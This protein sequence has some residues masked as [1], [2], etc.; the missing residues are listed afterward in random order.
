MNLFKSKLLLF[1]GAAFTLVVFLSA[2]SLST[3]EKP[4]L[5][6]NDKTPLWDVM[7]SLGK[8]NV[9]IA[10]DPENK[11][12]AAQGESLVN[13]GWAMVKGKKSAKI[14]TKF[15]CVACHVSKQ[16]HS[17]LTVIDPIQRLLYAEKNDLAYL[18]GPTFHGLVNRLTFFNQDFQTNVK[19][20]NAELFKTSNL[21]I[22]E[23]IKTCNTVFNKGRDLKDWE[24]EAILMYL[25]TLELKMGD[26]KLS[27]S[28]LKS[29]KQ[30]IE[31]NA[32]TSKALF[33]LKKKY[34]EAYP[35]SFKDPMS[36]N[37][38]KSMTYT[39]NFERGRI[40]FEKGCQHCHL[41][42][43]YS[44]IK[45]DYKR[46][47]FSNLKELLD[48]PNG[49]IY[50]AHRYNS[51]GRPFYTAERLS[52]NQLQDLRYFIKIVNQKGK[53]GAFEYYGQ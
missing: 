22:R 39:G 28:E 15:N 12:M 29:V 49:S 24:T 18:P 10:A 31:N 3:S 16:E 36:I 2:F 17:D 13:N 46:K 50:T 6:I 51:A 48:M 5:D 34:I 19:G 43:P 41:N 38:R 35:A 21:K 11:T 27:A 42:N 23:A 7:V 1:S 25:W 44:N 30:G 14:S 9:N 52:D 26:L 20:T 40:L 53:L 33:V 4:T 47:I 37:D 32:S 8:L 45:L